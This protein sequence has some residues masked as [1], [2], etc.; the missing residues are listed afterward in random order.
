M[1]FYRKGAEIVHLWL[2]K[3]LILLRN[4]GLSPCDHHGSYISVNLDQKGPKIMH[5][6][7]AKY[8]IFLG[9]GALLPCNTRQGASPLDPRERLTQAL[10][11][12]A[13]VWATPI[14]KIFLSLL[15]W[16]PQKDPETWVKFVE[17]RVQKKIMAK[18]CENWYRV[19]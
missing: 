19:T 1:N 9:K 7:L 16:P 18:I 14:L 17:N 2:Q 3:I 12:L 4:E 15:F 8:K 6:W 5:I 13:V 10:G 11:L